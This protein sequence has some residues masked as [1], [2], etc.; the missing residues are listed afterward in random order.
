MGFYFDDF[1]SLLEVFEL[2]QYLSPNLGFSECIIGRLSK[3][4]TN[5]H[6][7]EE[8]EGLPTQV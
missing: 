7:H 8:Y 3:Q 1:A 4:H 2:S 5:A 6:K